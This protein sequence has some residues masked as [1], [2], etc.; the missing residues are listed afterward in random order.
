[1]KKTRY[2]PECRAW[3][4]R[5]YKAAGRPIAQLKDEAAVEPIHQHQALSV[6][7]SRPPEG[8][9]RTGVFQTETCEC[10]MTRTVW[11][12][13]FKVDAGAWQ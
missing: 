9:R 1:M 3:K 5:S 11:I 10:G 7:P 6:S 12:T 2:N 4:G 8:L 13:S